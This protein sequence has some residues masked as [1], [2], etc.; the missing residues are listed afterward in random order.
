MRLCCCTSMCTSQWTN[1]L[2][3]SHSCQGSL[4]CKRKRHS[5]EPIA[6]LVLYW[7]A[8]A[9]AMGLAAAAEQARSARL[10]PIADLTA[11]LQIGYDRWA[12][13]AVLLTE[14]VLQQLLQ[15]Q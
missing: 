14:R 15:N 1:T 2:L 4:G 8:V 5:R 7:L 6:T 9:V 12:E 10:M 3:D 13:Q 11:D